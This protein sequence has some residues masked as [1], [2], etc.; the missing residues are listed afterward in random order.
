MKLILGTGVPPWMEV[1]LEEAKL[2][3]G[4]H[5]DFKPTITMVKKY[6]NHCNIFDN[7]KTL[8]T[9]EDED[10][11]WC[12]SF[13]NWCLDQTDYKG[14]KSAGSQSILWKEGKLFKRIKEPVF[15]AIVVMTNHRKDNGKK[16]GF[17]HV[18]FLYGVDNNE[19]LICLGGNQGQTIKFSRYKTE[20]VS[21][22]LTMDIGNEKKVALEQK[23]NGYFLP[24]NYPSNSNENLEI[25]NIKKL[26]NQISKGIVTKEN[27]GTR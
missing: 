16:T 11:S 18:T 8:K 4:I 10:L 26:N 5:E 9:V 19:N 22:R 20:G 25:Y 15:G 24:I 23:F 13:V 1:A 6:H 3:K 12:A 2:A 7:P 17:G 21:G 27:E 14:S